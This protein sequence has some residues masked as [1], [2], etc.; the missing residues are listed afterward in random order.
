MSAFPAPYKQ[1]G[2]WKQYFLTAWQTC[3]RWDFHDI[4]V[5]FLRA[6]S[7]TLL[8]PQ[9]IPFL[10]C[11]CGWCKPV[12]R[13]VFEF[14]SFI[15]N[16][17]LF[18]IKANKTQ[19]YYTRQRKSSL[20]LGSAVMRESIRCQVFQKLVNPTFTCFRYESSYCLFRAYFVALYCTYLLLYYFGSNV[21][22]PNIYQSMIFLFVWIGIGWVKQYS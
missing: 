14:D 18:L 9:Q 12:L 1:L 17:A 22:I 7:G 6:F 5:S 20:I 3:L 8:W 15:L 11:S 19:I 16:Q 4:W 2:N 10:L 21:E 13:C